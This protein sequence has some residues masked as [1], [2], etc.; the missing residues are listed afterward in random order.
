MLSPISRERLLLI[1]DS[2]F[3]G[4]MGDGGVVWSDRCGWEDF[5]V[6]VSAAGGRRGLGLGGDWPSRWTVTWRSGR[7]ERSCTVRELSREPSLR[8]DPIRGFSW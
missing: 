4:V 6:P 3:P 8:S 2:P 5:L 7:S 1:T